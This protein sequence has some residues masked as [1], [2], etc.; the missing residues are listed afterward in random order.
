M[1]MI[2]SFEQ[3]HG[4]YIQ[5]FKIPQKK[6]LCMEI[7]VKSVTMISISYQTLKCSTTT[8]ESSNVLL[9]TV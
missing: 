3:S 1:Y 2:F 8:S 9:I 4:D 5:L 7:C 6:K